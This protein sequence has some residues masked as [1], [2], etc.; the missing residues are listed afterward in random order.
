[1]DEVAVSV[2]G[3]EEDSEGEEDLTDDP[4]DAAQTADAVKTLCYEDVSLILLP[5]PTGPRDL[6]AMEV[7][8]RYHQGHQKRSKR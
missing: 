1:M 3:F 7:N 2:V 8:L 6:L 4:L 5:N